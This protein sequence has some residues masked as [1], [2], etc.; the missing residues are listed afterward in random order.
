MFDGAVTARLATSK[1][2]TLSNKPAIII[3]MNFLQA[4]VDR[5]EAV[6]RAPEESIVV[7]LVKE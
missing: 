4:R 3:S 7:D 1:T 5:A 6:L 2:S